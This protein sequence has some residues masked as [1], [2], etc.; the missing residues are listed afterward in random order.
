MARKSGKI[1]EKY[2]RKDN[3]RELFEFTI[4]LKLRRLFYWMDI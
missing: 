3:W 2:I 4:K 1:N